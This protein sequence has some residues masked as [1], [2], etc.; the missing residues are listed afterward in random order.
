MARPL[1]PPPP[2]DAAGNFVCPVCAK[3]CGRKKKTYQFHAAIHPCEVL[4]GLFL[5]NEENAKDRKLLEKLGITHVLN[6]AG[7]IAAHHDTFFGGL[8][9]RHLALMDDL[10][11]D[12]LGHFDATNAWLAQALG[13]GDL[14][15]GGRTPTAAEPLRG[16]VL[17][18]CHLGVSRAPSFVIAFL[19]ATQG[20]SLDEALAHVVDVR[21]VVNPNENFRRQLVDYQTRLR[22]SK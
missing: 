21:C 10:E 13:G 16:R 11:E 12:L 22:A 6:V 3:R 7:D 14:R 19:M 18:H 15:G 20:M 17:V 9:Y 4:P 2:R 8:R 1:V 5:G